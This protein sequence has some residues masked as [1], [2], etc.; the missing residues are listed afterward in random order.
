VI[1]P[2]HRKRVGQR[3]FAVDE[4]APSRKQP[5]FMNEQTVIGAAVDQ[6]IDVCGQDA[7]P[8]TDLHSRGPRANAYQIRRGFA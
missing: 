2:D 1:L 6:S 8:A 7:A 5:R 3:R 4:I